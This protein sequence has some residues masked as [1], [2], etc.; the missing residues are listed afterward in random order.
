MTSPRY[1]AVHTVTCCGHTKRILTF[2]TLVPARVWHCRQGSTQ[3][4]VTSR[5]PPPAPFCWRSSRRS[6]WPVVPLPHRSSWWHPTLWPRYRFS[7]TLREL[8]FS[9][10]SLNPRLNF[11]ST[12]IAP[13]SCCYSTCYCSLPFSVSLL[14]NP[15]T[16]FLLFSLTN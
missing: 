4:F 9:A 14:Q 5:W 6:P 15:Y 16:F 2:S 10:Q 7:S 8:P 11:A 12:Q 1:H 3:P 13:S